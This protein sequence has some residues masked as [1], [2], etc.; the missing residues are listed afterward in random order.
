LWTFAEPVTEAIGEKAERKYVADALAKLT[1]D[2]KK[3]VTTQ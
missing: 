3:S 2:L 1:D